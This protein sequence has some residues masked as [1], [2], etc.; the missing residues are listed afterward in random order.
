M[1]SPRTL[2]CAHAGKRR[3]MACGPVK[4]LITWASVI[5]FC[6]EPVCISQQTDPERQ[7]QMSDINREEHAAASAEERRALDVDE[8]QLADMARQPALGQLADREVSDLVGR[9]RTRRNRARDIANRQGREARAKS[10]PAGA[11]PARG[12]AGTLSKHDYLN[13]ALERAMVESE[14]RAAT[15]E[16]SA[17]P[18]E[19]AKPSQHDLAVKAMALKQAGDKGPNEMTEDGGPLHPLD[20]DASDGK[21]NLSD[22]ARRG[23]PSGAFEHAGELP[24]RE[25]SRTRY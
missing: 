1:Q 14:A 5:T 16:D 17:K 21:G 13:A 9:L 19:D 4:F 12:N 20:T 23:A 8:L 10:D 24:S 7:K 2:R 25:R 22:T 6:T 18:R 3:Y 11:T 15:G